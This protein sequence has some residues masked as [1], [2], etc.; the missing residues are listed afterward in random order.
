MV[1]SSGDLRV[2]WKESPAEA[3]S[4]PLNFVRILGAL[5]WIVSS[6]IGCPRSRPIG[7]APVLCAGET[8][9]RDCGGLQTCSLVAALLAPTSASCVVVSVPDTPAS[10]RR[11]VAPVHAPPPRAAELGSEVS[12]RHFLQDR[13]VEL[14]FRHQLLE[15]DIVLLQLLELPGLVSFSPP[16]SRRHR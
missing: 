4:C 6:P 3:R 8:E 7:G 14:F 15:P 13:Q 9:L 1:G 2:R 11:P 5:G 16:Y 10:P 12:L